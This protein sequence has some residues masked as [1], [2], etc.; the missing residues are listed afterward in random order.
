[1]K[2]FAVMPL[3]LFLLL[4]ACGGNDDEIFAK[5]LICPTVG[6]LSTA[7]HLRATG[8]N[9]EPAYDL[10]F[11]RA[12][13]QNCDLKKNRMTAEIR[14]E[15]RA[16]RGPAMTESDFDFRYFVALL[17]PEGDVINKS[18]EKD[19]G[20]FKSDRPQV[21]FARSYDDIKFEV[22][23]GKDGEGYEILVGFQLSREQF[24][25]SI[26]KPENAPPV[27]ETGQ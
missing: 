25:Q 21:Y 27:I 26:A 18:I 6:V 20:K 4:G 8:G 3:A 24:E 10:E 9:G 15:M 12:R 16:D 7:S 1:M 17:N 22:P 11:M 2:P 5:S 13:L 23:E 14:F 19:S